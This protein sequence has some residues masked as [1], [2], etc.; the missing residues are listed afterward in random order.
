MKAN[1]DGV[2]KKVKGDTIVILN[3]G[4][5]GR[6]EIVWI[7]TLTKHKRERLKVESNVAK[8]KILVGTT[9]FAMFS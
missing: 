8:N 3:M 6:S 9:E 1:G 4:G 7:W 5:I 2:I